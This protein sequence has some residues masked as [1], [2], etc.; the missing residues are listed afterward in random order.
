[1]TRSEHGW[2]YEADDVDARDRFAGEYPPKT[3]HHGRAAEA[4]Q[5]GYAPSKYPTKQWPPEALL[6]VWCPLSR[7]AQDCFERDALRP[8]PR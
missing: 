3:W 4:L 8:S 1:M 7:E 5:T 6:E 2:L